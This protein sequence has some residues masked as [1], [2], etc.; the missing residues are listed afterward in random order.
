MRPLRLWFEI[1]FV[2]ILVGG[3]A[4]DHGTLFAPVL[5]GAS[6]STLPQQSRVLTVHVPA[7]LEGRT[8]WVY[9]PPGYDPTSRRYPVLYMHDGQEL[10][11]PDTEVGPTWHLE[12][13]CD[14]LISLGY[15]EPFIVVGIMNGQRFYEYTPFDDG[16]WPRP[17]GGGIPYLQAI[18]EHLKPAIDGSFATL[19]D[20][21]HTMI[22]GSSLGGLI[23]LFAGYAY[24]NVFG[25]VGSF[26][27]ALYGEFFDYV[28]ANPSPPLDRVYLDSGSDNAF[29]TSLMYSRLVAQGFIPGVDLMY[30]TMSGHQHTPAYW[31]IRF[32]AAIEFLMSD[33]SAAPV[34]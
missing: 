16:Y 11:G 10:F 30:V 33:M 17:E 5:V 23:S 4:S 19:P 13:T 21:H 24:P 22:A 7:F 3:C 6:G 27:G 1:A 26:S 2:S 29:G 8:C 14:S 9:L 18:I 32:P 31:G 12:A 20:G 15:V 34:P 28:D 25:R